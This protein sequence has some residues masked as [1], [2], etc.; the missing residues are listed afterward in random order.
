MY[1]TTTIGSSCTYDLLAM[2]CVLCVVCV[3]CV[4]VC[5]CVVCCSER[6]WLFVL[7]KSVEKL[8]RVLFFLF[9]T[10]KKNRQEIESF[11][12][13]IFILNS[14]KYL[15]KRWFRIFF[16]WVTTLPSRVYMVW[17]IIKVVGGKVDTGGGLAPSCLL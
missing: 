5:V 17:I 4:C 9:F 13:Y 14:Q 6:S 2:L 12:S 10:T 1:T 16:G 15:F 11:A 3:V 8:K 7:S